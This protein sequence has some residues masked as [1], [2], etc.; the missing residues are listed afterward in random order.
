M[1]SVVSDRNSLLHFFDRLGHCSFL[2]HLV[3]HLVCF[4]VCHRWTCLLAFYSGLA[5]CPADFSHL[6]CFAGRLVPRDSNPGWGDWRRSFGLF[7]FLGL[8]L[9]KLKSVRF[10]CLATGLDAVQRL[11]QRWLAAFLGPNLTPFLGPNLDPKKGSRIRSH[12]HFFF[13]VSVLGS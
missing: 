13:D 12:F 1:I 2:A 6:P 10:A 7:L 4:F 5:C 9:G 8:F 3:T 11:E